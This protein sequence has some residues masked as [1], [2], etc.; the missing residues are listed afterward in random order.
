MTNHDPRGPIIEV[1]GLRKT[2]PGDVEA[3]KGI[4]FEV[5]AGRG[6]RPARPERRRQV[7]DDRHAHD[8]HRADRPAAPASPASTSQAIRSPPA[9]S[10]SVVFQDAGRRPRRSPA[11]ATSSCTHASGA[12]SRRRR[13][14]HRRVDEPLRPRRARRPAGRHLQRR[15]AAPARDRPRAR[16]QPRVLFL[17][18]PTVG[19]DPRI[20]HEL[21]D[22]I[23]GLRA[24][25]DMTVAAHDPL[26][27]RGRAALRPRGGRARSGGSSR[28]IRPRRSWPASAR[29][30]R[31]AHATATRARPCSS[32]EPR[33]W[34]ATTPSWSARRSPS[35][36]TAAARASD[37]RDRRAP[38]AGDRDRQPR[39]P[40]STTCTCA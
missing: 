11:A 40:P 14:A 15:P 7:D 18:E 34:P 23:G 38:P 17:D 29:A 31:A 27:R 4:D 36:C 28:S 25:S 12:S 30:R 32:C 2:Y 35:R 39:A 3:V 19:L 21:L 22:V 1:S 20:R 8:R 24:R 16:V 37:R 26:P 33:A 6:V 13:D 5:A 9:A 10:A